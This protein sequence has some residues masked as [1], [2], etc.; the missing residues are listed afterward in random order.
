MIKFRERRT[1]SVG[2]KKKK[3]D[4]TE[5][6]LLERKRIKFQIYESLAS[7]ILTIVTMLLAIV[8]AV[9]NWIE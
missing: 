6:E 3:P 4:E 2:K 7:I 9:L 1:A 5:K 8:T